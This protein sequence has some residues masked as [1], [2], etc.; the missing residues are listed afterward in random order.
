MVNS[1]SRSA[2]LIAAVVGLAACEDRHLLP[3]EPVDPV[4]AVFTADVIADVDETVADA[5]ERLLPTLDEASFRTEIVTVLAALNRHVAARDVASADAALAQAR[6]L[7]ARPAL[8][9][10]SED[11]ASDL[12]AIELVLDQTEA[13]LDAAAGRTS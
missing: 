8:T 12:G 4:A 7:V 9:I 5:D 10:E 13:L 11:F 3:I 2:L 6:A 1:I